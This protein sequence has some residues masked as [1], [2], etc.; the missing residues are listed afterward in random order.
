MAKKEQKS[1]ESK[2]KLE[3]AIE[4]LNKSYGVGTVLTLNDNNSKEGYDVISTGSIGFDYNVLGIGGF[5]LGKLYE[6]MGWEASGKS[7]ICGHAMAEC[8]KAGGVGLYVDGEHA[9]D[10]D[11]FRALGVNIDKLLFA[12]PSSGEEGFNI[13]MQ[14]IKTGMIQLAIIDSDSSLIPKA[15]IDGEVG[16][17]TIGKKARLNNNAYPAIKAA[18]SMYKV[19]VIVVSQFREKIGV[20]FGNPTTTQGGHALKFYTDCRL[21]VSKQLAKDGDDIYGNV[22]KIKCTKNKMYPP[23][24]KCE[25]D[26]VYGKGID[27]IKEVITLGVDLGVLTKAGSW[28]SYGDIKL[29]QETAVHNL[30]ED[31]LE[32]YEEIR[33]KIIEKL[34]GNEL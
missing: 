10:K 28:Y 13:V 29:G 14:M 24:R 1:D 25:F 6:L 9:F 33:G 22:T 16:D 17:S 8:Q 21:E 27:K 23:Y 3:T 2:N 15:V 5:A 31:N 11:Y 32:L 4:A 12:Q 20:M 19:C 18:L 7:T 34:K 30:F 26:I